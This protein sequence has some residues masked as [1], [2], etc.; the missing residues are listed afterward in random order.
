MAG[1]VAGRLLHDSGFPVT[2]L[3]A[4]D[5]LGGR[6]HTD[7][8]LGVPLDLGA[9][10]L[11]NPEENPLARWCRRAG[12]PLKSLG[13]D[14]LHFYAA[15]REDQSLR[16]V[17]WQGRRA[18]LRA[19]WQASKTY[20]RNRMQRIAGR[21]GHMSLEATLAPILGDV[22]LKTPDRAVLT[23]LL[24]HLEGLS[25]A[26]VS[27]LGVPTGRLPLQGARALPEGGF[28][29]LIKEATGGL[30]IW[31]DTPVNS[32]D[33]GGDGVV[34]RTDAGRFTGEVVVVAVPLSLLREGQ[35]AFNPPL[36]QDK[37]RALNCIGYGG[38]AVTNKMALRFPY[39]FWPEGR[40]RFARLPASEEARGLFYDWIDFEQFT[41]APILVGALSG[42][43]AARLD[44]QGARRALETRAMGA[45]R[46]MFGTDIPEPEASK[47]SR[48]LADPWSRGSY[49]YAAPGGRVEDRYRLAAPLLDRVFFCGEATHPVHYG[50]VQGALLTGERAA[51]T[52]HRL[53]G[54]AE[55]TYAHLPWRRETG[56]L[57]VAKRAR[58]GSRHPIF[59]RPPGHG[60][61]SAGASLLAVTPASS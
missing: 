59:A 60:M 30:D 11:F 40:A 4:R 52:I 25:A 50:T 36:P 46:Q 6:I 19:G 20:L 24:A 7:H 61:L 42:E 17:L 5:R 47:V 16:G 38:R 28:E 2:V 35:P 58:C 32:I 43:M 57:E 9:A 44:R 48:W 33:Y 29:T 34:V 3:E 31:L 45:L 15:E 41:G 10:W 12:I 51:L 39:R 21:E 53:Y 54:S 49:S 13:E 37:Q 22:S 55:T 1:L 26:P 56:K 8:S 18:L 27:D 23:W 14:P